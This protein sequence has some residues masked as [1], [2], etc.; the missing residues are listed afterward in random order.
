MGMVVFSK[1]RPSEGEKGEVGQDG[2]EGIRGSGTG[3]PR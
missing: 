2:L 3:I 1:H